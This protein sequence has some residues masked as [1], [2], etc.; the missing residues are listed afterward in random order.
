MRKGC[1]VNSVSPWFFIVVISFGQERVREL[2]T[3]YY[4]SQEQKIRW[5]RRR[6]MDNQRGAERCQNRGRSVVGGERT[7]TFNTLVIFSSKICIILVLLLLLY[8]ELGLEELFALQLRS[9]HSK[10]EAIGS[11]Q[12]E[13]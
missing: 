10:K 12:I 8:Y 4:G 1:G 2:L 13:S 6:Q 11:K 7:T 5:C 3:S 9:K